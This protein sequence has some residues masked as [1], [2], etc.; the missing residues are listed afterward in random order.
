MVLK[1]EHVELFKRH[2]FHSAWR[3]SADDYLINAD[4]GWLK[5][6]LRLEF[7]N[8]VNIEPYAGIYRGSYEPSAG[9]RKSH[10]LCSIGSFSYSH[11]PLPESMKVGR[12]CSICGRVKVLDIHHPIGRVTTGHAS[13]KFDSRLQLALMDRGQVASANF[14]GWNATKG[15]SYPII[16]NDV[17]IGQDVVLSLGVR[18]GQGAIIAANALVT[19]DVPP[20]AIVGG[21]PAKIIRYRFDELTI[22]RLLASEWCDYDWVDIADIKMSD[23]AVFLER[24]EAR[25]PELKKLVPN[26]LC[27]PD[28][29]SDE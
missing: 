15:L 14:D 3:R 23:V 27:L 8:S 4:I 19:K 18:V 10:G 12:F 22:E 21:N 26:I 7:H 28:A 2:R 16:G 6:G 9:G 24:F 25:K 20:Y 13:Y 1:S 11:S 17:W 29:F 5:V